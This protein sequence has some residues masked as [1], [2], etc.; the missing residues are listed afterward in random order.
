MG[1][2]W[3]RRGDGYGAVRD[4]RRQMI[5][6]TSAFLTWALARDRGLRRIPTRRVDR[7]GFGRLMQRPGARGLVARWWGT[8]LEHGWPDR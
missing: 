6:Q 4:L 3:F 2:R 5:D 7:G 8:M 1:F